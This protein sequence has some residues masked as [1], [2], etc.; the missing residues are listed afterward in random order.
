MALANL[1][2]Y[3]V[4]AEMGW[5]VFS[6]IFLTYLLRALQVLYECFLQLRDNNQ[7]VLL[8]EHDIS[9]LY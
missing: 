3:D 6:E 5:Y 9:R 4:W 8:L 7:C 2:G 1:W